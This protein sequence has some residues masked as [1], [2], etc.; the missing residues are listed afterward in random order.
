MEKQRILF[1]VDGN[2]NI[3]LG[4]VSRCLALAELLHDDFEVVF[5]I[6]EPD[7]QILD[8]VK[9]VS[10][11]VILLPIHTD[12]SDFNNE[13]TPHLTGSEIVV[14]DGYAFTTEYESTIKKKAAAVITIDDIPSRHFVADGIINFCGSIQQTE[15]SKEF[16]SQLYLGLDFLFLRSPFLRS[17]PIS[18][19]MNNTLLLNMGGADPGNLTY[20]ILQQI[21]ESGFSGEIEVIIGQSYPFKKTLE[22]LVDSHPFI[23]LKHGLTAQEMFNTMRYCTMAILPP[24]TVALE[25]LSTGGLLFLNQTAENQRCIN[26]YLLQ[27]KMAFDYSEF[28]GFVN[29]HS[30]LPNGKISSFSLPVKSFDRSSLKRIK[31]LFASLSVSLKMKFRRAKADDAELAFD[32]ANDPEVRKYSYS[33]SEIL[34][35]DHVQWFTKKISDNFC[36]YFIVEIDS[37][38]VGQIRFDLSDDEPETYVIS[39]L[40][41]KDWRGKGLGNSILVKGI[42]NLRTAHPVQKIIGYVQDLN[43]VSI[44]A[45]DRAGFKKIVS[46]E[47]P[48]SSKFELSF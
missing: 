42:Q 26:K 21:L 10:H 16:Y 2:R 20:K 13:L 6:R 8:D 19:R 41:S 38:P 48:K 15:Y 23:T 7:A 37:I 5:V 22:S 29:N 24:S 43:I 47:Y 46:L 39:Y 36:K 35:K 12:V 40:I 14:L 11:K 9:K 17:L 44:K 32:W 34:W 1:R 18:K 4:H 30:N 28:S 3:G 33:K 31:E 27:E 25:Y 45:F